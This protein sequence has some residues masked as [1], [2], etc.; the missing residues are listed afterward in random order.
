V[1]PAPAEHLANAQTA[2]VVI[3]AIAKTEAAPLRGGFYFLK[4]PILKQ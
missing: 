1:K 2:T 3:P 4:L